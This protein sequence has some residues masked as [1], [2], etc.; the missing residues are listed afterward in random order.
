M[1]VWE[2]KEEKLNVRSEHYYISVYRLPV[3]T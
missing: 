1:C 3:M 2:N